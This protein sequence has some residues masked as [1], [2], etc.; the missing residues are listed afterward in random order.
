VQNATARLITGTR[1]CD[2]I[3][4]RTPLA[5]HQRACQVQTSMLGS[6]VAVRAVACLPSRWLSPRL[7]QHMSL[8]V[9]SRCPDVRGT[10]NLQQLWRQNLC[11]C[12]MDLGCGTHYQSS[13]IIQTSATDGSDDSWRVISS[14]MMNTALCDL[15]Y[16]SAIEKRFTYLL[17]YLQQL[18]IH[19]PHPRTAATL[20]KH[21]SKTRRALGGAQVLP[22]KAKI[23]KLGKL[24]AQ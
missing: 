14:G 2:H 17:T 15:R 10:T 21:Y 7:G 3:T 22:T 4:P 11:S 24:D 6:P 8:S 5:T 18:L 23:R 13:C 20:P 9:V 19:P 16:A 1:R 12:C